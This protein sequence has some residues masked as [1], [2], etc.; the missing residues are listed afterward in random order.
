MMNETLGQGPLRP[1]LHRSQLHVLPDAHPRHRRPARGAI[2]DIDAL[3]RPRSTLQP[4]NQFISI[5]AFVLGL[6]QFIFVVNFFCSLFCGKKAGAQPVAQQHAGMDRAVAAAARQLRDDADRL[7]RALRVR[8]SPSTAR[9]TCRRRE[10]GRD[11]RR[12]AAH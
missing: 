12:S 2:A 9:T 1:D 7:P 3:R 6:A 4:L 5:S 10:A 11:R 8:R